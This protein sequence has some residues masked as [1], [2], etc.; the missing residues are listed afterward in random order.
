MSRPDVSPL[1]CL[2]ATIAVGRA[3]VK[4]D[5]S[6]LVVDELR[7]AELTVERSITVHREK[8]FIQQLVS[9]V[10]NSNEADAILLIGG[11]GVGPRDFTCKAVDEMAD[12]RME[13]FGEAYRRLLFDAGESVG[14]VLTARATA[15]VCDRCVVVA[16]PRRTAVILRRAMREL[17]IPMLPDAV[18]IADGLGPPQSFR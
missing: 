13:G 12:R 15:G 16:L 9:N 2:V 14:H 10:A 6:Q 4:D 8:E 3:S 17:V 5:V 18:R 7:A 11:V 1:R